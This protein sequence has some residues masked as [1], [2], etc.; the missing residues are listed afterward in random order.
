[1]TT[2]RP[3]SF[4]SIKSL[5]GEKI[6][7]DSVNST[8]VWLGSAGPSLP[9]DSKVASANP[10]GCCPRDLRMLEATDR[11][12]LDGIESFGVTE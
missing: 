3:H 11:L 9:S 6:Y 1:V 8:D 2:T 4:V 10:L 5:V 12:A 7:G